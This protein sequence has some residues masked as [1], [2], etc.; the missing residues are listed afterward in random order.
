MPCPLPAILHISDFGECCAREAEHLCISLVPRWLLFWKWYFLRLAKVKSVSDKRACISQWTY[1]DCIRDQCL[2]WDAH[3]GLLICSCERGVH[4]GLCLL[5]ARSW[6]CSL[7]LGL[8][9][10]TVVAVNVSS[11]KVQ[12]CSDYLMCLGRSNVALT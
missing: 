1:H 11:F 9:D 7:A 2:K 4:Y 6:M 12:G 10:G 3:D 8:L 5:F